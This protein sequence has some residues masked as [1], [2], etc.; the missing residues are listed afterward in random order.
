MVTKA[1]GPQPCPPSLPPPCSTLPHTVLCTVCVTV[2][3]ECRLGNTGIIIS[4]PS[5]YKLWI[6]YSTV[7]T[8]YHYIRH[9]FS[10]QIQTS[11]TL[12]R[13]L[14]EF[15]EGVDQCWQTSL[16]LSGH[17]LHHYGRHPHRHEKINNANWDSLF[18]PSNRFFESRNGIF[19]FGIKNV[20]C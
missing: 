16:L 9:S 12:G 10:W 8:S 20:F 13:S 15:I 19:C 5:Q 7:E 14:S 11:L 4:S 6:Y 2:A 3:V 18:W 1:L 17:D